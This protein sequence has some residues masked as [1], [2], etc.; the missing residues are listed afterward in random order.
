MKMRSRRFAQA[1]V[2]AASTLAAAAIS[3]P[4]NA[5]EELEEVVVTGV[6]QAQQAA[7]EVKRDAM[8]VVDSI[9]AEDIGKLPDV[10]IADSLQ[11][12]PGV[13]IRRDAGEG[14][15]VAVRGLPQVTTLLNGE[16]FLGANSTTTVQPD[17]G[18]IPSQLFSGVDVF[19]T[20][21]ASQINNG[22]TGTVN[23]KT[24]RPFD[25]P[26]GVTASAA[27]D[28]RSVDFSAVLVGLAVGAALAGG[29]LALLLSRDARRTVSA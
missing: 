15:T 11:R 20:S 21:T 8:Q 25:L 28:S 9:S 26:Q 22:I 29:A 14:S 10:T 2:L 16:Q 7:I 5:A 27:L 4:T 12:I 23:L 18:D 13:Q 24:R 17:F 19:K 6:R 1:S 3:M